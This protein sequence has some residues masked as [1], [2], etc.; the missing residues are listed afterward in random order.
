MYK[1]LDKSVLPVSSF[2]FEIISEVI[3]AQIEEEEGP[4]PEPQPIDYYVD[5]AFLV[6]LI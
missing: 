6:N 5:Y 3:R 4:P 2:P 1:N